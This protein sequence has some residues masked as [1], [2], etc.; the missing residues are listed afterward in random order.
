MEGTLEQK[1]I[2]T[3]ALQ[4]QLVWDYPKRTVRELLMTAI[5]HRSYESNSPVRF[6]RFSDRIEIQN[7]GGFTG[8][9]VPRI[10]PDPQTRGIRCWLRR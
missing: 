7:P 6:Y 10:F 4:D 1:P 9:L 2:R 5:C 8:T 3:G